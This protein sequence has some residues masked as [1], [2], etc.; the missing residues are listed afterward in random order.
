MILIE[1]HLL[2]NGYLMMKALP[3]RAVCYQVLNLPSQVGSRPGSSALAPAYRVT[4]E[5]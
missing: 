5:I 1:C 2:K 3:H 4:D